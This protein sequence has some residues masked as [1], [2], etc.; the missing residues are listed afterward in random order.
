[1]PEGGRTQLTITRDGNIDLPVSVKYR[2][3][4]GIAK[5]S[6]GD[7]RPIITETVHFKPGEREISFYVFVLDDSIPETDETFFV[8]LYDP[9]PEG[10]W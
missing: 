7:Y 1:M 8:E 2:T 10:K 6:E 4:D 3:I 5:A 9:T